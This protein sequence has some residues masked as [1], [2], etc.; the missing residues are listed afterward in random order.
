M[1]A[2]KARDFFSEYFDGEMEPGLKQSFELALS[3]DESLR[4]DYARF[5]SAMNLLA[6][7][8]FA[9]AAVPNDLHDKI[10]AK[11]DLH[12]YEAK[13][14]AKPG[15][16]GS[17]KLALYGGVAV[18]AIVA[19]VYGVTRPAQSQN[20]STATIFPGK[21]QRALNVDVKMVDGKLKLVVENAVDVNIVVRE[22]GGDKEQRLHVGA[23][24]MASELTN[25]DLTAVASEVLVDQEASFV[26]VLPGSNQGSMYEGAGDVL[27]CAKA[28]A[29]A[30]R[31]PIMVRV[32]D[33]SKPVE[34]KL[35]PEGGIKGQLT[36]LQEAKVS[37][38]VREDGLVL[39]TD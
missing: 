10:M 33:K 2:N 18:V 5:E 6:E 9:E 39:M 3:R 20:T 36:K 30:Y 8:D 25:E 19:G 37:L 24:G 27:D 23:S 28:L 17:W 13:H 38:S 11:L 26:I 35:S 31:A 15:L 21:T 34:W 32:S 29:D 1:N 7:T 14:A 22:L 4:E 12:D 16:F